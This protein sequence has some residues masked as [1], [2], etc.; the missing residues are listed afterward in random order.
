MDPGKVWIEADWVGITNEMDLMAAGGQ[1][2]AKFRGNNPAS[3]I[4][5][6][7]S[8]ADL[9]MGRVPFWGRSPATKP[10]PAELKFYA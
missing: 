4:S 3:T 9:H 5:W 6:I 8:Y 7:A 10:V 1:L 2:Q